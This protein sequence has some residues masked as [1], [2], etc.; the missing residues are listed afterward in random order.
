MNS[1]ARICWTNC[2]AKGLSTSAQSLQSCTKQVADVA[3]VS[4]VSRKPFK[5]NSVNCLTSVAASFLN[6]PSRYVI[7]QMK[8]VHC[9]RIAMY[10]S[11]IAELGWF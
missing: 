6:L 2:S 1:G 9:S 10:L 7:E 11:Q 4:L 3:S 5:A 8:F